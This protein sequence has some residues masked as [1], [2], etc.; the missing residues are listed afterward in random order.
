M[1]N[2]IV[3]CPMGQSKFSIDQDKSTESKLRQVPTSLHNV[4]LLFT[5]SRIR[6]GNGLTCLREEAIMN[7]VYVAAQLILWDI[8]KIS[9]A[10]WIIFGA[11]AN[12]QETVCRR[13]GHHHDWYLPSK[14][15][16]EL[17]HPRTYS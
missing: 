12:S 5:L 8:K 13:S 10:V 17:K 7:S 15:M 11:M 2:R 16:W 9:D 14:Q 1:Q 4:S 3:P 6:I